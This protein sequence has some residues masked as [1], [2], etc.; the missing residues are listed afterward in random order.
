MH[1]STPPPR[2]SIH[3]QMAELLV[4]GFQEHWEAWHSVDEG[5]AEVRQILEKGFARTALADDGESVLGWIGGLPDY[6]GHVWELHPLVVHPAH[7]R[8]GL[9]RALVADFEQ[10]VKQRGGLTVQLGTD[11]EDYMTTLGG[12]DLYDNLW[13]K[14]AHIQNLKGHPYEFYQ[15]C[16]YIITGVVPDANG[17]GKPDIIMSKRVD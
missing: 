15:K 6:D 10:Q 3:R 8:Q 7:Q 16:G 1:I 12:A 2:E 14:I 9:G 4:V 17:R 13:E 5:L 11:D